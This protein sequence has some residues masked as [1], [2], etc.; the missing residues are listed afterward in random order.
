M[1]NKKVDQSRLRHACNLILTAIGEKPM[2]EGLRETPQRFAKMWAEFI[3]YEPGKTETTFAHESIADQ[4]VCVSG[5]RVYSMCEHH[6]LPF[7]CDV[8][9]AY[10]PN[11]KI[12][13]L[14]KF[15]RIAKKFARRLQ[16][17]ERLVS[18]IAEEIR[19]ISGTDDVAV[20][21]SGQHLCMMMRGAETPATMHSSA[22]TG[23]FL[24]PEGA[25]RAEFT[26]LTRS[27]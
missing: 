8:S 21:A 20:Q 15:A 18:Q 23:V 17:Q 26:A 11:G 9:V 5:M 14:S 13:G 7:W 2:R 6:I 3:E 16:N 12:M 10:I 24:N 1:S 19:R 25:A 4:M 27:K 22:L